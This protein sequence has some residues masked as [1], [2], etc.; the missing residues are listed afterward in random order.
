MSDNPAIPVDVLDTFLNYT[1]A[2]REKLLS[3]RQV[4]FDVA[5]KT[6]G[7]GELEETLKWR[8][9]SYLTPIT[10]SGTTIRIDTIDNNEQQIGIFV[11]CQTTLLETYRALYS[12]LLEFEGD[13]CVIFDM[14]NSAELEAVKRCIEL[15]LTYHLDKKQ[16]SS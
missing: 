7:V 14:H 12:D 9:I 4:I 11:T 6:K 8:Q 16:K 13:R 3:L 15:A 5:A 1:E 2:S 10:K